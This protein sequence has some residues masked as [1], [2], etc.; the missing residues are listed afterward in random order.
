MASC[1]AQ[2]RVRQRLRALRPRIR[3]RPGGGS[4]ARRYKA[5]QPGLLDVSHVVGAVERE[6][7]EGGEVPSMRFTQLA[8]VGM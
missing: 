4:C 5:N 1:R 8:F 6:V 3:H 7:T 2:C